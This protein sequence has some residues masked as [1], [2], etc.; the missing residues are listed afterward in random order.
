MNGLQKIL[1]NLERK[2]FQMTNSNL[3]D[4]TNKSQNWN[5]MANNWM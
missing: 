4:I 1:E 2:G 5:F 3:Y